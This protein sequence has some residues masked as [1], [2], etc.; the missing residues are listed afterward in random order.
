MSI[1]L[2]DADL[3]FLKE[4]GQVF[5]GV[6]SDTSDVV[7]LVGVLDPQRLDPVHD[8]IRHFD[9]YFHAQA[10]FVGKHFAQRDQQTAVAAADI[11]KFH[12]VVCLVCCRLVKIIIHRPVHVIWRYRTL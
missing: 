8:I 9:S 12:L 10:Q 7:E 2:L 4:I 6:R 3:S 1:K 11:A 5:H